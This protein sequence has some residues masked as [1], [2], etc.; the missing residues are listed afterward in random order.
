M[1]KGLETAALI[2]LCLEWGWT[3]RAIF[4]PDPLPAQIPA[5]FGLD[6]RPNRWGTPGML[7]LTPVIATIIYGLMTLVARYPSAFNFPMRVRPADRPRLEAIA[8]NLLSCLKAE[9][10]GIFFWI[11]YQTIQVVRR[12][13]GEFSRVF[14]PAA[15]VAVFATISWHIFVMRRAART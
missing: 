10:L 12:G 5:H 6:G 14:I 9:V 3:A 4:G 2:L 8:L 13:P 1:R 11:Q 15:L 7:W